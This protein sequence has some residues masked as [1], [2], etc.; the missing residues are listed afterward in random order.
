MADDVQLVLRISEASIENLRQSLMAVP[1]GANRALAAAINRTLGTG[2]TRIK[3][4]LGDI[5]NLPV[6]KIM[7]G[8]TKKGAS[9]EHLAGH[10]VFSRKGRPLID[11]G[12]KGEFTKGGRKRKGSGPGVTVTVLKDKGAESHPHAFLA[13]TKAG[14]RFVFDRQKGGNGNGGRVGRGPTRGLFGPTTVGV[15]ANHP[16]VIEGINEELSEVLQKNI[17]SQVD[18]FLQRS[19]SDRPE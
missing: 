16:G 7:E 2:I 14:A 8:M 15:V 9:P 18:R 13:H 17:L 6:G 5:I 12:A 3:R 1:N 4:R 19:R 10:I 11:Y